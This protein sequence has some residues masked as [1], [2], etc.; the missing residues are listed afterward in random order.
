[1]ICHIF[2]EQLGKEEMGY[3]SESMVFGGNE[4]AAL[5]CIPNMV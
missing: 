5:E 2:G 3:R 1:M 4:D